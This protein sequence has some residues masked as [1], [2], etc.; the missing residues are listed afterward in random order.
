MR[1]AEKRIMLQTLD[2]LWKD[3]LLSLDHLR[4]GIHLRGYGQRDP[5]NEYKQEAFALFEQLLN[6][7]REMVV[8]RLSHLE[9]H[10]ENPIPM[11]ELKTS[12]MVESRGELET[13]E[14]EDMHKPV[15][16]NEPKVGRNDPCPCGSG[17]KFKHCHGAIV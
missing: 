15:R 13:D 8:S 4:Q 3:H 16:N 17:K 14:V 6:Q 11:P 10:F 5:L 12:R 2:Q 9:I 1:V 7:M